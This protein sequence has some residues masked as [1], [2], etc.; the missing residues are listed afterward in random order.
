MP[1]VAQWRAADVYANQTINLI[2]GQTVTSGIARGISDNGALLV[3]TDLGIQ[4]FQGGEI[5]VRPA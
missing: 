4:A 5:S 2:I 1:F 3:E